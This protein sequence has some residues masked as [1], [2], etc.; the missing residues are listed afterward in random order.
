[1]SRWYRKLRV[2]VNRRFSS[3]PR[4]KNRELAA[5]IFSVSRLVDDV[6]T[7]YREDYLFALSA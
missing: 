4:L 3:D 5:L 6:R 1:M 7:F 2:Q